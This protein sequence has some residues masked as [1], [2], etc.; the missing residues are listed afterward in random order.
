MY[1]YVMRMCVL[2]AG[3]GRGEE[4][5]EETQ[6]LALSLRR[7]APGA[8]GEGPEGAAEGAR[9]AAGSLTRRTDSVLIMC[10]Y[11]V[12]FTITSSTYV[13]LVW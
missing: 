3:L 9:G 11:H 10:C 13:F 8:G 5:L 7:G 6:A 1:E 12:M 2:L 4:E